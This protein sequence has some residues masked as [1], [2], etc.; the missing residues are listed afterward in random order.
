MDTKLLLHMILMGFFLFLK[1]K[2]LLRATASH[3]SWISPIVVLIPQVTST[4]KEKQDLFPSLTTTG[5]VKE[6][7]LR[8]SSSK[9]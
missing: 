7:I 4:R 6:Q 3:H 5:V 9:D 1:E 8:L 2:N